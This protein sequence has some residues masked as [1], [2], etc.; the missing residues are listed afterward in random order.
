M[1]R[2]VIAATLVSSLFV[3][4]LVLAIYFPAMSRQEVPGPYSDAEANAAWLRDLEER[5]DA[6]EGKLDNVLARIDSA[7]QPEFATARPE[8]A[9]PADPETADESAGSPRRLGD[10]VARL[11]S[12][13]RDLG[14]RIQSLEEDPINRGYAFLESENPELRREGIRSL[15]R[16]ARFDPVS[17]EALRQ[18]LNDP[19]PSVRREAIDAVGDLGDKEAIPTLTQLLGDSDAE[20]RREAI[21]NLGKLGA[22]DAGPAIVGLLSDP[23][24]RVR[25]EAAD[26]LG[27]LGTRDATSALIEA[28][29]DKDEEVRG[30]SIAALGE[31]G[32]RDAR[33]QLRQMY[34]TDPG[35]HRVR[36]VRALKALGDNVPFQQEVKRL[37]DSALTSENAR[38]RGRAI[39][40]LSWFAR[41]QA[42]DVFKKAREDGNEWVRR[43]AER[44]LRGGGDREWRGRG[45]GR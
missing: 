20:S 12:D 36:L 11:Q 18:M 6:L 23:S 15:R 37:S 7:A 35:R 8:E 33:P 21:Q 10:E 9:A 40:M 39:Q 41:E 5:L 38:D 44:A 28:L 25:R 24:E 3:S 19:D 31:I 43:E 34:D 29:K 42:Q 22:K 2:K 1:A 4:V 26:V 17:R 45:R 30:E 14:Y 16:L 32:A 27:R 13:V